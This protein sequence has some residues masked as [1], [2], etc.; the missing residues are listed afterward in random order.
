MRACAIVVLVAFS[1]GTAMAAAPNLVG[2]WT[3]TA[4]SAA[5]VG[6]SAGYPA[7]SKPSMVNSA[8]HDWKMQIVAQDGN[9]FSGTLTGPVG[10][11][12]TIVGAFRQDGKRFVFST[13]GDSGAGEATAD[14]I[15]YCWTASTAHFVGA[16]CST[17]KRNK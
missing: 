12:Q 4:E 6:E 8:D 17:F 11:P 5:L 9:A 15:E 2:S 10:K 1:S 7:S 3:R 14:E 13:E 16:G